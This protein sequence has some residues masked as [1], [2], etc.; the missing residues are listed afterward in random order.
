MSLDP[1]LYHSGGHGLDEAAA[2]AVVGAAS[3]WVSPL[4]SA[5]VLE[6]LVVASVAPCM[7]V[8]ALPHCVSAFSR[9]FAS[10]RSRGRS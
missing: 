3:A 1:M 10:R 8:S 9:I 6:T 4:R 2:V 7:F 5:P